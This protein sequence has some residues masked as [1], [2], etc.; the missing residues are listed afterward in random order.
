MVVTEA[1]QLEANLKDPLWR[2]SNL[3]KI[4]VKVNENDEGKVILFKPNRAQR[5]FIKRMW[6]R[7]IILKA[8][9][10]G[11]STLVALLWLDYALFNEN[12]RCGIIAQDKP[13]A[14]AIFRDKVKF[15]YEN[16]PPELLA[17]MPLKADN[18]SELL[19][20]HNNSSIRVATSMRSGTI[21]RLHVSE[22]GKICAKYPDK[23]KEVRTGSIP[24]V[25]KSGII[26]IESTAEGQDGDFFT[27]TQRAM[28]QQESKTALNERDYRFHFFPWWEAPEYELDPAGINLTAKD[29]DYFDKV[30]AE[31]GIELSQRKRAWYVATRNADFEESPEDMWQ[32]YP[33]TPQEAFQVST[34]GCYYTN[35]LAN[36]RKDGRICR[37]P[38][39][40]IPVDTF[41]DIGNSDMTAIW[42]KQK[43]G[44]EHRFIKYYEN[45]GETL[46]H[47]AKYLQD[48]GYIF[49]RHFLP[50]DANHKKLSDTNKSVKEMLEALSVRN[51]DI[52]P[53]ITDEL[54][55]IQMTRDAFSQCVFDEVDCA[56]GLKRLQGF[57][58]AWN[59]Q[60]GSWK[61][62]PRPND[63][64]AH[65]ADAF[66]QFGQAL[67]GGMLK[68]VIDA[69]AR[70]KPK[71]SWRSI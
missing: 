61:P 8:R 48:T 29:R 1:E 42:F 52:V 65:G 30:E 63:E 16:L 34:E 57:K 5:R 45:S 66:R 36:A 6:H 33:S 68:G 53:V 47:Y 15:A 39:L 54:T 70:R 18:S 4:I 20:A 37:I 17:V 67:D 21:D 19:F 24:A 32:E 35:Q 27:M 71:G 28:A 9:Q 59:A 26:I 46:G 43:V 64:N 51:I 38:K 13:S 31:I 40:E 62:T 14:E 7:N 50:H 49:G 22:Y 56:Q 44:L 60:T 58:K 69:P 11:F 25:P 12:A 3:Y 41:W 23:A 55:G 10:L 2:L